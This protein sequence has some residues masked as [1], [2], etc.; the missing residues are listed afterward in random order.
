MGKRKSRPSEVENPRK[1]PRVVYE[2]PTSEEIHTARQLKQLLAFDQDMRKARHGNKIH[3]LCHYLADLFLGLQSFK[4]L[5]DGIGETGSEE[6]DQFAILKEYLESSK[7][8]GEDDDEPIYLPDIMEIW[9]CA[10]QA[11]NDNVLS[12]VAV[13]LALLLKVISPVLELRS[14]GLDICRTLLQKR[15]QELVAGNLSAEKSKEFIISPTLRLLREVVCFDGGVFARPV[16]RARN[17]TCKFLARNMGIKFLGDGIES[18]KRPSARTNAIRFFVG[19]LKF[20]PVEAKTELLSQKDVIAALTRTIKDDPPYL[21]REILGMLKSSVLADSKLLRAVKSRVLNS[22]TL[23]RISGLYGYEHEDSEDAGQQA[24]DEAAHE[25]LIFACTSP[26]AGILRHQSGLYPKGVEPDDAAALEVE[27]GDS[28]DIGLDRVVWIDKFKEDIPVQ[29]TTLAEFIQGLRPWSSTRQS[30]LLVAIFTAAPEL[31]AWYFINKRS[32]SFEPKLSATWMG[33]AALLFN[34][35]HIDLPAYFGNPSRYA[36]VPPPTSVL[37][38]NIIPLPLNQKVL[39]RCLSQKSKLISFFATRLLVIALDKLRQALD[40][41]EEASRAN[42]PLWSESARR[43]V[44]EFCQ[45]CP[46][47]KEVINTYRGIPEDDLLYREAASRVL[48]LY[49]EVIPQAALLAKFDVSPNLVGALR[50]A[51]AKTASPPDRTLVMLE[52]ENLLAIAGYSPGMRWFSKVDGLALSPFVALVKICAETPVGIAINWLK[53]MLTFVAKEQQ[54]VSSNLTALFEA[55]QSL[56]TARPSHSLDYVWSFLDNCTIRCAN[57]P[58]KYLEMIEDLA[59]GL[60]VGPDAI[61]PVIMAMTEQLPYATV[62]A[63]EAVLETLATFL[64]L[65]LGF[66]ALTGESSEMLQR[67]LEKVPAAFPEGSTAIAKLATPDGLSLGHGTREPADVDSNEADHAIKDATTS[68]GL[69]N[70][71]ALAAALGIPFDLEL[72]NSALSRWTSK[73]VSDLVEDGYATSLIRL[74]S[75]EH[76]SIRKEAITNILKMAAKVRESSYDEKEQVWLLLS[77]L[78]ESSKAHVDNEP[79]PGHIVAFACHALEVLKNPLHVLY[80]KVN[81]F[82]TA[83]PVWRLD[84]LPLVHDILQ[85]GPTKD[86]SYYAEINWLLKYLLDSLRTP[87]DLAVFHRTRLFER[88]LSTTAN[89]YMRQPLRMQ[90]L[91]IVY[92]ASSIDGG[93]TTLVTR[94]GIVSWLEGQALRCDNGEEENICRA[95]LKRIWDTCD[96]ERITA[97]S[98]RGVNFLVS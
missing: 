37:I 79:L 15:Q 56:R 6:S 42:G 21:V 54:L 13:A 82:L 9:S 22:T 97:W 14:H 24:T 26:R 7:P 64:S 19:T 70:Q 27:A 59:S 66:C 85:A 69:V 91:K 92:R 32:F 88:V 10:A 81:S 61:S 77:E 74:L 76:T 63:D 55:L 3:L 52:L 46:Q 39:G 34:T 5:L 62:H 67:V 84:K 78:A 47:M 45:R 89:P 90:V 18:A 38:D 93:S 1:R 41:H 31:V 50:R 94:F 2:A 20:L 49:Y 28:D 12:A 58:V 51:G 86:D 48:R 33:Y 43:V 73:S 16:F 44:D 65:Y 83:A 40:L 75:S 23:S 96:Q 11:K 8:R 98:K 60:P 72:D 17:Y 57:T 53:E 87:D 30:E 36:R 35:I 25:F 29:N 4:L 68:N 71:E 80:A 95:V